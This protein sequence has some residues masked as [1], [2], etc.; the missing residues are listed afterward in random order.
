[1]PLTLRRLS[2]Q[3]MGSPCEIQIYEESRI[4]AK[5]ITQILSSEVS[6]L[7][8]KY[9]RFIPK[10]FLSEINYSAG[11]SMGIKIDKETREQITI[12]ARYSGYLGR[13]RADIENL[14]REEGLKIPKK[15]K[16]IERIMRRRAKRIR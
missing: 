1:M 2:F 13:Q 11:N 3:A 7:E 10:S 15:I 14:K 4:S 8:R 9:S 16:E 12:E 6:R 5:K